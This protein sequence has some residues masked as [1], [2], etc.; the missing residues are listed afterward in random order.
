ML[1]KLK[2]PDVRSTNSRRDLTADSDKQLGVSF[3]RFEGGDRTRFYL[4]GKP[5]STVNAKL[6]DKRGFV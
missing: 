5:T 1:N 6:A 2:I 3:R 4:G